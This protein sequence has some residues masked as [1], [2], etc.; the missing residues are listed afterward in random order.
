MNSSEF[1]I[2]LTNNNSL[3]RYPNNSVSE[4]TNTIHP[5][6]NL[7]LDD[8][9][10]IWRLGVKSCILPFESTFDNIYDEKYKDK[11]I[12]IKF[13]IHKKKFT[14]GSEK[15]SVEHTENIITISVKELIHKSSADIY[16]HIFLNLKGYTSI[17]Y[18]IL[19][20][21]FTFDDET[22]KIKITHWIASD[23][24]ATNYLKKYVSIQITFNEITQFLLGLSNSQYYLFTI[25]NN[26]DIITKYTIIG[27]KK[28]NF[29]IY[30]PQ[31]F[32]I[33]SDIIYPSRL[34]NQFVQII[35]IL[36]L[37]E[38]KSISQ[39]KT[40]DISY[41]DIRKNN[42]TDISISIRNPSHDLLINYAQDM[43][44]GLHFKK[45]KKNISY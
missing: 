9:N 11:E 21:M 18:G 34:G 26:L 20:N 28:I 5:V 45:F 36:T 27:N 24:L 14:P 25:D 3:D 30:C 31:Y 37:I 2:F 15:W 8:E 13:D 1:D 4:F 41:H 42:I 39:R 7:P 43:I 17:H 38:N 33:Y 44:L 10:H 32:F 29:K 40:N 35:D 16:K 23:V 12:I 19:A 22:Q 6:I